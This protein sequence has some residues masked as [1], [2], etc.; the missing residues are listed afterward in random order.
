MYT[1]TIQQI[2][3]QYGGKIFTWEM[4]SKLM[5][6]MGREAAVAIIE[7]LDLPIKPEEYMSE[8]QQIM[9]KMFPS[10]TFLPGQPSRNRL[11]FSIFV[12]MIVTSLPIFPFFTLFPPSGARPRF[13][14]QT[15]RLFY[16]FFVFFFLS[17]F[18]TRS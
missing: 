8:S 10:C 3:N 2:A 5:G 11:I 13:E 1:I 9:S 4:K 7:T 15:S 17:S 12:C 6:M 16:Y 14:D 18:L